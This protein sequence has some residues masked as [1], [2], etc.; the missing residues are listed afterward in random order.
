MSSG[1]LSSDRLSPPQN[2][3]AERC[4]LGSMLR[5]NIIIHDVVQILQSKNFISTP[6]KKYSLQSRRFTIREVRS[7]P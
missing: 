7:T 5:D 2:R 4:V 6:I 1:I 3:D